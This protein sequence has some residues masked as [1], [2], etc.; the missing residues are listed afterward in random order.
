MVK[1]NMVALLKDSED[2]AA[3][4]EESLHKAQKE[5]EVN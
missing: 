4:L 2:N 1:T 3:R 5:T